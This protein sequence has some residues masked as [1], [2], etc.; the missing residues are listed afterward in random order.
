MAIE[1]EVEVVCSNPDI[2][3]PKVGDLAGIWVHKFRFR[4]QEYLV[5][6][7]PPTPEQRA[8]GVDVELLMIDF[9]QVGSHENFY[10]QLKLYL[11]A[12]RK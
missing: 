6:Y 5:A 3:E 4:S 12:E 9:Y 10:A 7:R 1:D 2:G 11:K 8:E